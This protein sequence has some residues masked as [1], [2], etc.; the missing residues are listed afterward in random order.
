MKKWFQ[1]IAL[2]SLCFIVTLCMASN[3]VI[4]DLIATPNDDFYKEHYEDC[5]H[6]VRTY[7]AN[8]KNGYAYIYRSPES[9]QTITYVLNGTKVQTTFTYIDSNEV[10]WAVVEDTSILGEFE[11]DAGWI[12]LDEF[13]VVYDHEEFLKDHQEE[14]LAQPVDW[15]LST[16]QNNIYLWTYPNSGIQSGVI[17]PT[18]EYA[19]NYTKTYDQYY[20]DDAGNRWVY[21][22]YYMIKKGWIC[23]DDPE[24][25]AIADVDTSWEEDVTLRPAKA[26]DSWNSYEREIAIV[27][28]MVIAVVLLT[29]ILIRVLY[30]KE[31]NK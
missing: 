7:I 19:A 27:A 6:S 18:T 4:A 23:I 2:M 3:L 30:K 26:P 12:R 24:N 29:A 21:I 25:D 20:V 10:T 31:R 11:K 22:G 5:K 16:Y 17:D 14:I 15:D 13:T 28:V 9:E 8:S 1:R